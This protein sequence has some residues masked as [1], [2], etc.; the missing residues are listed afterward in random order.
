MDLLLVLQ[1]HSLGDSQKS[2]NKTRFCQTSKSQLM[3]RCVTSLGRSLIYAQKALPQLNLEFVIFDDHSDETSVASLQR[4]LAQCPFKTAFFPL[5]T[6]GIMPSILACYQHGYRHGRK[7]VYFAQDDYLY[8]EQAI[9]QMLVVSEEFSKNLGSPVS[10]YPFNDPY[11]YEPQNAV[12]KV[13]LVRGCGRHWRTNYH[14]ASCFMAHIDVIRQHWDLFW[15]FGNHPVTSTME[16]ATINHLFISR[17]FFLFTPIP[18]LALH[19]Q[20]DTEFDPYI[21]WQMWWDVYGRPLE[22][23][24]DLM[25]PRTTPN[26]LLLNS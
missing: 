18:S 26:P 4:I 22:E 21:D 15:E 24:P 5:A 23:G 14:T 8:D 9:L 2:L 7:W 16:D 13:H 25:F 10:I 20:Y 1:T 6:R 11:R 3:E 19:M 12:E 17:G